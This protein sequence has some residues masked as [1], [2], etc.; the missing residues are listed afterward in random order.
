MDR[1]HQL[2]SRNSKS[3]AGDNNTPFSLLPKPAFFQLVLKQTMPAGRIAA[4]SIVS[5]KTACW[6]YRQ[7][8]PPRSRQCRFQPFKAGCIL[9]GIDVRSH[10]NVTQLTLCRDGSERSYP[11]L[12]IGRWGFPHVCLPVSWSDL[13][14]HIYVL[15]GRKV[16]RAIESSR[17]RGSSHSDMA[18]LFECAEPVCHFG[19]A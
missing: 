10:A 4:T 17:E 14:S 19:C 16:R 8:R 12:V 18:M 13:Q 9:L 1:E 3:L 11:V 7:G 15:P 5:M 2:R 6:H